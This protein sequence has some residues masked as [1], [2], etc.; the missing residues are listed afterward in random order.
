MHNEWTA[1]V[2]DDVNHVGAEN[3]VAPPPLIRLAGP[4]PGTQGG[5]GG[6]ASVVLHRLNIVSIFRIMLILKR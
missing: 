3:R 1:T 5:K 2:F 6:F 4:P